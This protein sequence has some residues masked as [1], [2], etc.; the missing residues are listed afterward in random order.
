MQLS[1]LLNV[2]AI[3]MAVAADPVS[4]VREVLYRR[5]DQL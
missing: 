2:L 4:E 1:I 5:S 3:C